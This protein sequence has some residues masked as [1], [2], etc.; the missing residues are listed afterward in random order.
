MFLSRNKKNNI[1]PCKPR[2]YYIK[3]GFKGSKLHR[4]VFV[5]CFLSSRYYYYYYFQ[6]SF[7]Y[8][9]YVLIDSFFSFIIS[10]FLSLF[11]VNMF[12]HFLFFYNKVHV[13]VQFS[14]F[15]ISYVLFMNTSL[16]SFALVLSHFFFKLFS[17]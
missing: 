16:L 1:Y 6:F 3:V 8:Y 9:Q 10:F 7:M 5:M 15:S 13:L 17:Y 14:P 11:I 2:F 12:K 4:Y